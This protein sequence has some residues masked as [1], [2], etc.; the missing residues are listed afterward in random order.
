MS[1]SA[2][3]FSSGISSEKAHWMLGW[4]PKQS[5]RDYLDVHER[6]LSLG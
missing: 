5:W 2:T 4:T 1:N 6:A 3:L